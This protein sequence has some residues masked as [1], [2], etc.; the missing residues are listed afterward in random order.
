MRLVDGV[1][2]GDNG[3]AILINSAGLLLLMDSE[4][5]G[6]FA[7]EG[8]GIWADGELAVRNSLIVSNRAEASGL[9]HGG[10]IGLGAGFEGATMINTTFSDNFT[11]GQGGGIYTRRS[12]ELTNVSIIDN[13]A[14]PPVSAQ[15]GAGLYQ[16]FASQDL[17]TT[18]RN[19]LVA[20]NVNGG[21]GGTEFSPLD[22]NNG[23]LDEANRLPSPSC[24]ADTADNFLVNAGAAG[25]S[26]TLADNGG[27]TRTHALMA[28]SA[29]IDRGAV[30]PADDQR[31]VARPQG[32]ACD[33]GAYEYVPPAPQGGGGNQ[34]PPDDEL[35]E[36]E[37]G[38]TVNALPA[39]G[40]V[41]IR[42]PGTN[43]FVE[44]DEGQ[45]I[46]V[47]TV[48]DTLKGRVTLVA[49]GGQQATSMTA[50]SRSARAREPSR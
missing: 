14:P 28:G 47:G 24:N 27:L 38:E 11:D 15:N 3:G 29:A 18:A 5:S 20:L 30:C 46:P 31:G 9:G 32:S 4:I 12:M 45:Q 17:V 50:S 19:T 35:P 40:T 26:T 25:V 21:C 36:P 13:N 8:G 7:A 2:I 34:P 42:L 6:N 10:G 22:S 23:L 41:K 43:R 37:A 49:A 1:E 16:D 48:V 39:R 33:I 44:L